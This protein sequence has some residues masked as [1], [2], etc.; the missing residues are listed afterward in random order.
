MPSTTSEELPTKPK[1]L[2]VGAGLAGL[3]LGI[4]LER[5][6]VS[7]QIYERSTTVT[8]LGLLEEFMRISLPYRSVDMYNEDMSLIGSINMHGYDKLL[9]YETRLFARPRLYEFLLKQIPPNKISHGKKVLRMGEKD[10]KVFIHC[11][12]NTSY[13]GDI[14]VGADGTYSGVRQ[15]LYRQMD[16]KGILPKSDLMDFE[17]GSVNMIGVATPKDPQ[18]YPQLK[19][20]VAHFSSSLGKASDRGWT[21]MSAPDNQICWSVAAALPKSSGKAQ[22][23]RN[24][25]W[26]PESIDAMYKEFEDKPCPWGGTMGD[27]FRDTPKDM[28]S[29]VFIEE[30]VFKTWHHGRA[31]LIGD[32]CHK[33]L[34]GAGLGA[35]NAMHDAV[36]LANC[37]YNLDDVTP[38]SIKAAFEEYY[39]QR[40][41]RVNAHFDRSK[42]VT[43]VFGGKTWFQRMTRYLVLNYIPRWIQDWSY[44]KSMEYRP[45]I[46]WL[47]LVP[48]R[49]TGHVLPQECRRIEDRERSSPAAI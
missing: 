39:K 40:Y 33:M 13:Q 30:K 16:A 11:A 27:L 4:L 22:Q 29:K 32:A 9:G 24:S 41:S 20:N 36:V 35:V 5:I 46:A 12:D 48:N 8:P 6:D 14:L 43:A 31:V 38:K 37:I 47:P 1:V 45:Q 28:I 7:Y 23:F 18:R 25:E 34:P 19:D 49:G 26:G 42:Q 15:S 21:A 17:V 10:G 44:V 2:I 3:L